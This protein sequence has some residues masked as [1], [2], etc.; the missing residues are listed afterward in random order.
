[1]PLAIAN[2]QKAGVIGHLSPFMKIER[3]RIGA[4]ESRKPRCERGRENPERAKGA[5]DVKPQFF[6]VA[7]RTQCLEVIDRADID[8]S[9]RADNQ[10][11]RQAD[12]AISRDLGA[13]RSDV[14]TV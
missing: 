8:R 1:M 14:D 2:D 13:H 11:R 5:I 4:F 9:G 7:Q 6:F 10:K 12:L 3:D